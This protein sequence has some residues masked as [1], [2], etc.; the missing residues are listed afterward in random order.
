VKL[1][2]ERE[3]ENPETSATPEISL[4]PTP[5]AEVAPRETNNRR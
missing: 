5:E 4:T 3:A 2:G 1:P